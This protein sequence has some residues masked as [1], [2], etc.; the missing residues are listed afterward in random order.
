VTGAGTNVPVASFSGAAQ[1]A[2]LYSPMQEIDQ[3]RAH[4][5]MFHYRVFAAV[6]LSIGAVQT[7]RCGKTLKLRET[8]QPI[9]GYLKLRET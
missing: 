7:K 1:L 8:T 3:R 6:M 4:S 2:T 9:A 5:F